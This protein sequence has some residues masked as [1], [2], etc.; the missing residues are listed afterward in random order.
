MISK[1]K[2]W[3]YLAF[4]DDKR[5]AFFFPHA[6]ERNPAF[7]QQSFIKIWFWNEDTKMFGTTWID[8]NE[9]Y[10]LE[11]NQRYVVSCIFRAKNLKEMENF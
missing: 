8:P 5:G 4:H 1:N 7:I 3:S 2:R 10:E 9:E 6:T 11:P